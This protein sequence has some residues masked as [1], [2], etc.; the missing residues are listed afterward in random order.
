[1]ELERRRRRGQ[2]ISWKQNIHQTVRNLDVATEAPQ[3]RDRWRATIC[4]KRYYVFDWR[5]PYIVRKTPIKN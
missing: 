2:P 3:D 5:K 1:M 4:G